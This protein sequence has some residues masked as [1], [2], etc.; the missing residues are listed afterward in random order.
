MNAL[1]FSSFTFLFESIKDAKQYLEKKKEEEIGKKLDQEEKERIY[2]DEN[3]KNILKMTEKSPG[4]TYPFTRFY[5]NDWGEKVSLDQLQNVYEWLTSQQTKKLVNELSMSVIDFSN[6]KK[7]FTEESDNSKRFEKLEDEIRKIEREKNTK[8]LTNSFPTQLK[9]SF[10]EA[11]ESK[12][13]TFYTLVNKWIE[14]K[15]KI[16]E[17][18]KED[19]HT[20]EFVED[21]SKFTSFEIFLDRLSKI[22]NSLSLTRNK[23]KTRELVE[24]HF[25]K[26]FGALE[27]EV[28][29][30]ILPI[31]ILTEEAQKGMCSIGNWCLNT[32]GWGTYIQENTVQLN[33]FDWRESFASRYYLIGLT[34]NKDGKITHSADI[35]N[36]SLPGVTSYGDL[37]KFLNSRYTKDIAD[38]IFK[39]LDFAFIV[40][41][42]SSSFKS[43]NEIESLLKKLRNKDLENSLTYEVLSYCLGDKTLRVNEKFKDVFSKAKESIHNTIE[44]NLDNFITYYKEKGILD[45]IDLLFYKKYLKDKIN[46]NE[47]EQIKKRTLQA[48]EIVKKAYQ[49]FSNNNKLLPPSI[50]DK[51]KKAV[52]MEDEIKYLL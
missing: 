39:Y 12:K 14:E 18:F 31:Y 35:N 32:G 22:V 5:F 46:K 4:Y 10:R 20:K 51:L 1:N 50:A 13:E 25:Q 24:K 42:I 28:D 26:N 2:N 52:D 7:K 49:S 33:I 40:K 19:E 48:L 41:E 11:P 43:V 3:F 8:W 47:E 30:D 15:P 17:N 44:S 34:V 27:V 23:D 37:E 38:K 16:K 6:P 36:L 45:R 29:D 9:K 21:L